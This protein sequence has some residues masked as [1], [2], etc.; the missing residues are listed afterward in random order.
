MA[1][2]G[3][4]PKSLPL[5]LCYNDTLLPSTGIPKSGPPG[6]DDNTDLGDYTHTRHLVAKSLNFIYKPA[7]R[8]AGR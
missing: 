5:N 3:W 7:S 8:G 4:S 6:V 1:S 2:S